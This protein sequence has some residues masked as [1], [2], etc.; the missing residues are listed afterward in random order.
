[1]KKK[2]AHEAL[3]RASTFSDQDFYVQSETC[4]PLTKYLHNVRAVIKRWGPGIS[5][6]SMNVVPGYFH[7]KIEDK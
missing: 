6:A 5:L 7:R 1:M 4:Y 3:K 2:R